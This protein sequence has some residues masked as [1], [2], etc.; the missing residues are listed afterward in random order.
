MSIMHSSKYLSAQD[1]KRRTHVLSL[2]IIVQHDAGNHAGNHDDN[3]P[4][5]LTVMSCTDGGL[6]G[7]V[8]SSR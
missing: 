1:M 2:F 3:R 6:D 4:C 8:G 5:T 7:C